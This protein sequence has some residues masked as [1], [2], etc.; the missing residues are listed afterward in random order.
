[1]SSLWGRQRHIY[2]IRT[3]IMCWQMG[4]VFQQ[5]WRTWW[6]W[7]NSKENAPWCQFWRGGDWH[8]AGNSS[9]HLNNHVYLSIKAISTWLHLQNNFF[10]V[11]I[12]TVHTILKSFSGFS[13]VWKWYVWRTEL[14][15]LTEADNQPLTK[16]LT[17][18]SWISTFYLSHL[19]KWLLYFLSKI[20]MILA[21]CLIC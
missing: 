12:D 11:L 9:N 16:P 8:S 17:S 1:M 3:I 21:R 10:I 13:T 6:V 20:K 7:H 18:G 14:R 5:A 2:D 19:G 15:C 4:R